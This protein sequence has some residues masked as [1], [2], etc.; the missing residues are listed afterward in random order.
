MG[1][2]EERN[3]PKKVIHGLKNPKLGRLISS[4]LSFFM[5]PI[6]SLKLSVP[7][8]DTVAEPRQF[9]LRLEHHFLVRRR[10]RHA[11]HRHFLEGFTPEATISP[12]KSNP[13][14]CVGDLA[15]VDGVHRRWIP[16]HRRAEASAEKF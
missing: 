8:N 1:V 13:L 7:Q 10:R 4:G 9:S 12:L 2:Q 6:V 15:S 14:L 5:D 3:S 16:V 11:C